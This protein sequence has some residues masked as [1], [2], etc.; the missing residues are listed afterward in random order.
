MIHYITTHGIGNAWVAVE[1]NTLKSWRIP[2]V[3][4]SMRKPALNFYSS[5]WAARLDRETRLIYPLPVL[6]VLAAVLVGPFLYG[7]RFFAALLNA[8][9]GK[10][11]S[12]RVRVAGIAHFFVACYWARSLRNE[13]VTQ[14]HSQWAQSCASI[15]M[16]GAWLL[17]V[18]FSFTGHAVDLFRERAALCDKIRRAEFIVCIS[19]FHRDFYL[20]NGACE[21]QLFIAYCGIDIGQFAYKGKEQIATPPHIISVGRLVEKKGFEYLI[22]A[23]GL[24]RERDREL[25]CTIAG[26]GP[27]EEVLRKR[28]EE[29]Q[30]GDIVTV[31][32]KKILQEELADFMYSGDVFAQP[33]VWSKDNDVDGT[34]RTLMEAM[35]CGVPSVS[36]RLAG[37]PDIIEHGKS[38]LLVEPNSVEE[39]ADAIQ[40]I[41]ESPELAR[42][43]SLGGRERIEQRFKLPECVEPLK[44]RF[45]AKLANS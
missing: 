22:D 33:C 29:R 9:F 19:G 42:S 31:T 3:L 40:D 14:I 43:L 26:D 34:P 17:D 6:A 1:L 10:R 32:G 23:C 13:T 44:K 8:L 11:E 2:V 16:H 45:Q 37:I 4:H 27:L 35:A 12:A 21:E 41:I 25:H 15:G 30:L 20:Q 18:P 39:L 24:L 36:T 38:G 28:V 5:D 7:S